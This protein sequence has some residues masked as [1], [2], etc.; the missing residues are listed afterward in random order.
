[1]QKFGVTFPEALNIIN[2]DFQL[3][4]ESYGKIEKPSMEIFGIPKKESI[5]HIPEEKS[6][7]IRQIKPNGKH[8]DYWEQYGI[9]KAT[10]NKYQVM[11]ISHFWIDGKRI[12]PYGVTF[13]Y[14]FGN[15]KYKIL[16]PD[17]AFKWISN[18][19]VEILQG[20]AQ[21]PET[22]DLLI[23]TSSL[24][25]VMVLNE[26][27]YTAVAPQAESSIIPNKV[28]KKLKGRFKK[29]ILYYNNDDAGLRSMDKYNL[30]QIHN[31][32]GLPKDPSD[33]V[34]DYNLDKAREV[35]QNLLQN[36]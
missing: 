5:S 3:G 31:P 24:K 25:D 35:I 36:G 30:P 29:I 4:L 18:C 13:A 33:I 17:S 12:T 27:G 9:S 20:Y 14:N 23:I 34:K 16:Q 11:A 15:K 2:S 1:M 7:N 6:I 19:S 8:F 26:L 28:L 21:L 32:M 10:L 22:G